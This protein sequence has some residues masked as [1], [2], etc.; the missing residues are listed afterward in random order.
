MLVAGTQPH[1]FACSNRCVTSTH[2]ANDPASGTPDSSASSR[3]Y[4]RAASIALNTASRA[5]HAVS[6]APSA[7]SSAPGE[8]NIPSSTITST[9][10][11]APSSTATGNDTVSTSRRTPITS[12]NQSSS[13]PQ[14]HWQSW[15]RLSTSQVMVSAGLYLGHKVMPLPQKLLNRIT[16][17]DFVEIQELLPKPWLQLEESD[18]PSC[19]SSASTKMRKPPIINITWLQGFA[20]LVSALSTTFPAYVPE[21]MAYQSTIVRCYR[22]YDGL[23]WVQY[24]QTF[25]RQVAV[26]K[27]LNSSLINVTLYSLCFAGNECHV[28]SVYTALATTTCQVGAQMPPHPPARQKQAQ[29]SCAGCLMRRE[30]RNAITSHANISTSAQHASKMT[31]DQ[32]VKPQHCL[33]RG[34]QNAPTQWSRHPSSPAQEL[35][36]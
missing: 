29:T 26:T 22:D 8:A 4:Y 16:Y 3:M 23:C 27:S 6:S 32:L 33:S 12:V 36:H 2:S 35:H 30:D 17:L 1:P 34:G 14:C 9:S 24:D 25:R 15:L 11:S 13:G 28:Y 10:C 31:H 20:S 7:A 18:H 21:F 5:S 19:C